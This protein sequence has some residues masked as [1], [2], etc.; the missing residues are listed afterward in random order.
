MNHN[1][2]LTCLFMSFPQAKKRASSTSEQNDWIQT[3]WFCNN[4]LTPTF[5]SLNILLQMW[6]L[7][8]GIRHITTHKFISLGGAVHLQKPIEIPAEQPHHLIT[9]H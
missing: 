5:C 3:I 1:E 2:V 7:H 6:I 9:F 8:S 4:T